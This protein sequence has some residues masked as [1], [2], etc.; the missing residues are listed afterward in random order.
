MS[1][2]PTDPNNPV[3]EG[4]TPSKAS[5]TLECAGALILVQREVMK[6]QALVDAGDPKALQTYRREHN[7]GLTKRGIL[8]VVEREM[9]QG[10]FGQLVMSK[11]DLDQPVSHSPLGDWAEWRKPS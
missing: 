9:F 5:T 1:C 7:A 3:P 8:V 6:L 4:C 10:A 2:H 11:P